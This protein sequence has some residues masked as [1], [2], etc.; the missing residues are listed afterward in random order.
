MRTDV[1]ASSVTFGRLHVAFDDR[2]LRPRGW[3][4]AQSAWAVELLAGRPKARVLELC[5]GAGQIGLLAMAEASPK[6]RLVAV[7]ANPVACEFARQNARAAGLIDQVEVREGLFQATL[8]PGE[9]FDL[10][11][12]DPP[13]VER[14]SVPQFPDD[15]E[16]A[17]DGG[18][19]GLEPAF[20][21]LRVAEDHLV[22]G[23]SMLLQ[24]GSQEQADAVEDWL[25]TR[26]T[27]VHL[28]EVRSHEPFGTLLHVRK[29]GRS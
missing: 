16:F 2:V 19:D 7:D 29:A 3:T 27:T 1:S 13:W 23:G 22:D 24:L 6:T 9:R 15:P 5:C 11:I 28:V 18:E 14:A 4:V 20:A 21:C 12:A 8:H 26:W 17:I 10:A 25:R